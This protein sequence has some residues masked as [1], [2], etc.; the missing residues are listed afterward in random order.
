MTCTLD[1]LNVVPR[2]RFVELVGPV[3]EKSPWIAERAASGRPY[4]SVEELHT[5]LCTI[6][7][8][9]TAGEQLGLIRAHP[10]LVSRVLLTRESAGEQASAGLMDLSEE[11]RSLFDRYNREYKQRFGFPFVIC[12]RMN[13]KEAI[14]AAF[15]VRLQ[16]SESHERQTALD[17]ID[18]IA[19]IRLA[20]LITG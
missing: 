2:E 1:E 10:D 13:R 3:F 9:A 6:V 5:R 14:L 7:R 16:N 12:A 15:P 19:R 8:E 11:E 17:E 18:K 20:D 4:G